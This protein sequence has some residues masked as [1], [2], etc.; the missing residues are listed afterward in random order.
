MKCVRG[1]DVTPG[2]RVSKGYDS[3][4]TVSVERMACSTPR[5]T[6]KRRKLEVLFVPTTKETDDSVLVP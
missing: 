3:T 6:G 2:G 4:L 1:A 5:V